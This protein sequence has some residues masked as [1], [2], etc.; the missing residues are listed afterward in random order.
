MAFP[1]V[2]FVPL[3]QQE[4]L[5]AS[6]VLGWN[7]EGQSSPVVSHFIDIAKEIRK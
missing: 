3:A 7:R 5:Q 4:S 1:D 6:I 2:V